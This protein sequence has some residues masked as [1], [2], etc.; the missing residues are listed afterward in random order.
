M[1]RSFLL[2]VTMAVAAA[3]TLG[4]AIPTTNTI[5]PPGTAQFYVDGVTGSD[6]TG[7][8]MSPA[9]AW[10]TITNGYNNIRT[11]PGLALLNV[12]EGTYSESSGETLPIVMESG[13]FISG[14]NAHTT[15]VNVESSSSGF[16]FDAV[17]GPFDRLSGAYLERLTIRGTNLDRE[18]GARTLRNSG[19]GIL[20][21]GNGKACGLTAP[22]LEALII[23]GFDRAVAGE[24]V[25]PWISNCTITQNENGIWN[26]GNPC[27]PEWT[28]R[29]SIVSENNTIDIRNVE[30]AYVSFSIFDPA[31]AVSVN[32]LG[33]PCNPTPLV[34]QIGVNGNIFP[35]PVGFIQPNPT[36]VFSTGLYQEYDFRLNVFSG[37]IGQGIWTGSLYDAE[38]Y[39]NMRLG[40]QF[41]IV[42]NPPVDIGADQYNLF[43]V[44]P[45]A[46]SY[47]VGAEQTGIWGNGHVLIMN[48]LA[49]S[50]CWYLIYDFIS[51]TPDLVN[52]PGFT[53]G[54]GGL[55]WID[56]L[57][58]TLFSFPVATI[59]T[60]AF[61]VYV[62]LPITPNPL[63][64]RVSCQNLNINPAGS[65]LCEAQDMP[66][67][68]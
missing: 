19:T 24:Y 33:D 38:G 58:P 15:I 8:G 41:P 63:V 27:C 48:G 60:P 9:T 40:P 62:G 13:K 4:Q 17:N 43:R 36:L 61:P 16:L 35:F 55:I 47:V 67:V 46:R 64:L 45:L 23:Y 52:P 57:L 7:N 6:S 32:T 37:A 39:G 68:Y 65:L 56:P 50:D 29:N 2:L 49:G 20:L 14:R 51:G 53:P 10:R 26:G 31:K 3:F 1:N 11:L 44:E 42:G 25:N 28:V 66:F 34:P 54:V 12:D 30:S 18:S 59:P 21:I 22:E 5:Y